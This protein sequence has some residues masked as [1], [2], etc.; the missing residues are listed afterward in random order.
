MHIDIQLARQLREMISDK[1][2]GALAVQDGVHTI[3]W[4]EAWL[5][6][7]LEESAAGVTGQ[8]PL[9]NLGDIPV[10][11]RPDQIEAALTPF[12]VSEGDNRR[13]DHVQGVLW[14]DTIGRLVAGHETVRDRDLIQREYA[15]WA[16]LGYERYRNDRKVLKAMPW[17]WRER[18]L[19]LDGAAAARVRAV[20]LAAVISQ[21]KPR[22]VLEV[23]SGHGINLLSLAGAFPEIEFTG[24]ELT[25]EGVEQSRHAQFNSAIRPILHASTPGQSFDASAI[26]RVEFIQGDASAMPFETDSFD[27]VLT[28]VAV[29][30]MESIRSAA[31][32]EISRVAR[33]HVLMIEPFS[34]VN[35]RGLRRLYVQSRGYFRG[36][37]ESLHGSGLEPLWATSD[38]PQESFLGT[39]L[40][41]AR[42][43]GARFPN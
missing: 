10:L 19:F 16:T 26:E 3:E 24:L 32:C 20:L 25:L 31:L 7:H 23:G 39:A 43:T 37:I 21:L 1:G 42:A 41:L 29:E 11:V 18:R 34:D 33:E 14:R 27:L 38:F 4:L 30:Q 8:H 28:V 13:W 6:Q 17:S 40:V 2:L 12:L 36:S 35:E 9:R 15:V 22:R 5:D